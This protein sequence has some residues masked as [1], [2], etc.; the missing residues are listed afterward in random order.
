M[1]DFTVTIAHQAAC[2]LGSAR[3]KREFL[4][5]L[6]TYETAPLDALYEFIGA[7]LN[8]RDRRGHMNQEPTYRQE[9]NH[10]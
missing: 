10:G 9:M 3:T 1:A 7:I 6:E 8:D 4:D 5:I 2:A